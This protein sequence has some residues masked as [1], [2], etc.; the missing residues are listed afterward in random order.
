MF[1]DRAR[2]RLR[3]IAWDVVR[4]CAHGD[5]PHVDEPPDDE[6]ELHLPRGAFVTLKTRKN[7]KLR[8]CIGTVEAIWPAWQAVREMAVAAAER[9]PRFS[10]V[11][12]DELDGLD[13]EVS[14]L[15]PMEP[16]DDLERIEIGRH[17]LCIRRGFANGLLLP[18]VP[19]E[20]GWDRETFLRH[21]C[22]KAGL[23]EDAWRDDDVDL[24]SFEAEVF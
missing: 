3:A 1:S 9:D 20:Q 11:R 12:P 24:R 19:V 6:P 15:D 5:P 17:G 4:A 16:V 13:L 2:K 23:P 8:G 10:P 7:R 21:V 22:R 14:L 18:Q